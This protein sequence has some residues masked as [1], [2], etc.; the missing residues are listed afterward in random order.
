MA[1]SFQESLTLTQIASGEESTA[2]PGYG[3][4]TLEE[5]ATYDNFANTNSVPAPAYNEN[6][7]VFDVFSDSNVS[8]IDL[9]KTVNV[10]SSQINL[11]QEKNSQYIPFSLNRKSDGYDLYNGIIWIITDAGENKQPYA[12]APVNVY[13]TED[14]VYFGWLIDDYITREARTV[15]FEIH[16]HGQVQGK[17]GTDN[18]TYGYVWKSKTGTLNVTASKF[19][20]NDALAE[21]DPDWLDKIIKAAANNVVTGQVQDQVN[22][23]NAAVKDAEEYKKSAETSAKNAADLVN[24]FDTT[25]KEAET[26]IVKLAES[27]VKS[28]VESQIKDQVEKITWDQEI[29]A[30]LGYEYTAT[31]NDSGYVDSISPNVAEY[32]KQQFNDQNLS[33]PL[34]NYYTK[35]EVDTAIKNVDVSDSLG[36]LGT[37]EDG[38]PITVKEYVDT[39]IENVDVTPKLDELKTE[40]AE[41][42]AT[43]A[44]V[45]DKIGD[46]GKDD[47]GNAYA[48]VAAAIQDIDISDSLGELGIKEDGTPLTVKEY[49]DT[50]IENVDVSD[51]LGNYALTSTVETLEEEVNTISSDLAGAVSN[52]ANLKTTV[53]TLQESAA[54]IYT[55]NIDYD[56]TNNLLS[57]YEYTDEE[58]GAGI[59]KN[60]V[61]ITG[62]SGGGASGSSIT[63]TRLTDTPV[64]VPSG[65]KAEIKY[66]IEAYEIS[67]TELGEGLSQVTAIWKLEGKTIKTETL[68][69]DNGVYI[70]A[71]DITDY[72]TSIKQRFLLTITA[73]DGSLRTKDWQAYNI[74]LSLESPF[75]DTKPY[76]GEV[77]FRYV[78]Y[79]NT[80][81]VIHFILDNI[82]LESVTTSVSGSTQVYTL[83]AQ[84]HGSHLLEV[85]ATTT[86]GEQTLESNHIYKDI[87]WYDTS[88]GTAVIGSTY[89]NFTARQY[90]STAIEYVVYID[91][92]TETTNATLEASYI[93]ETTGEKVVESS[94]DV[95]IAAGTKQVW[96]YKS[97]ILGK[98]TLTI[99]VG[100][101]VK[102]LTANIVE[103]G[104]DI[105]PVTAG[106][107]FDFD[108]VGYNND[109][110]NRIWSYTNSNGETYTMTLSDNFDWVN[111]GYQIDENGDQYFLIK[112]GTTA[113]INY[114][115]FGDDAKA[116]GKEFKLIF[117][118]ENV[119]DSETVFL[120]CLSEVPIVAD[121]GSETYEQVGFQM[122][123][124]EATVY[125]KVETL[126][127][128]YAE[129]S[130]IEFE[131]NI[132][133]KNAVPSMVMGYEDGV[134]TRPMVYDSTHEFQQRVGY[135][136]NI[137]LGSPDCDL[138][139]YRF[140][141]YNTSLSDV[142]IL[143]NFI[144]DARNAEEMI[145]RY[146]RNQIYDTLNNNAL[147]PEYLAKMCP[148]LRIIKIECPRFTTDK[149]D[150]VGY[151]SVQMIYE[152]GDPNLDN[153][154]TEDCV[155]SGQG[156]SSNNYGP[157]G[158]NLDLILKKFSKKGVNYNTN[159][160]IYYK[161]GTETDKV[162]LTRTSVP[163]DYFNIK[164]NI[165]S[166]ENANNALLQKRYNQYNPY[167]RP[168]VRY[169]DALE[170][171]YSEEEIAA[172]TESQKAEILS[173]YQAEADAIIPYIKDTMEFHNCVIFLRET[174]KY[175]DG[176]DAQR[177][178][179]DDDAWHFYA[180]GNIG[181]S[182]KT[183]NTRLTDPRDPYEC[184]IEVMDNTMPL[185]TFPTGYTNKDGS[186][187]YPISVEE[188]ETM[189]NSAY[190][191]LS[192]EEF[193]EVEAKDKENGLDD[194]YGMRY[195]WED[196]TDEE[197]EA[198]WE[199]VKDKWKEF[200][201]F[202]VTSS[203]QEFHDNLGDYVVLNSILYYYLFTLRYT[204]TD[205]HAKN[206]FWHYGKSNDLDENGKPIR[207]WDLCF[208]YDN[209]TALGIDNYGRM[210]YR[211][212]YEEID[213]VDGTT[214]WVWNAPQH[215]FFLRIRELFDAELS[216]LFTTL[217]SQGAFSADGLIKQWNESQ[218][219]FPE[220]LWRMDIERKYIRTYTGSYIN[221]PA[222]PEFL[223]ERA[224]GRKK[225]QRE[226]FERSQE[227][228]M[229][230]KFGGNVAAGDDI[231]L[232]C[233]PDGAP[234]SSHA[235]VPPNFDLTLTPFSYMYLNVKY[236]TASPVKIRAIPNQE[237]TITYNADEADIMEIYSASCLKSLGDLS[238]LYLINGSFANASKIRELILGNATEGYDNANA[239]SLGLGA[240]NL[241]NK[242]NIQNMSGL[243]QSLNLSTL[244]NLKELY[245]FGTSSAG[246]TFADGGA[247]EVV[248][249]PNLSSLSMKNLSYLLDSGFATEGFGKLSS[250]IAENSK[251]DLVPIIQAATNLY[252]VR[253][254]GVNW[255][256][257]DETMTILDRLY[258]MT[259][260]SNS[261]DNI[262]QSVLTGTV[263]VPTINEYTL[264][265]YQQAW[266]ELTI[267]Y[268]AM[269]YQYPVT[270]VNED[271]TILDVQYVIAGQYAIDPITRAEN[272]IPIPTKESTISTDFTF[273]KWDKEFEIVQIFGPE[274]VTATYT[275]SVRKYN[276]E[277]V[278][279]YNGQNIKL[280]S[281]EE[282]VEYGS[283]VPYVGDIPTYTYEESS[284]KYYVFE[285][286]D[287]SGFVWEGSSGTDLETG[288]KIITAN[289]GDGFQ[290]TT[291]AFANKELSD[292]TPV[293]IYAIT[294]LGLNTVTNIGKYDEE[295]GTYAGLQQMDEYSFYM[296]HDVNYDDIDGTTIFREDSPRTFTGATNSL[297]NAT[298]Y[299]DTGIKLFDKDK[300]FVLA[301]DFTVDGG[302]ILSQCLYTSSGLGFQ[303]GYNNGSVSLSWNEKTAT[304]TIATPGV[305][306][307]V[308]LRHKAGDPNLYLYSS[309]LDTAEPLAQTIES[310]KTGT[311]IGATTL[312]FG[313]QK[314]DAGTFRNPGVG[315]VHWAKIWWKDLGDDVCKELVGWTHEKIVLEIDGFDR[316][317]IDNSVNL[318]TMSLLGKQLLDRQMSLNDANSNTGGYPAFKIC[319]ILNTRFYN[320]M[321]WPIQFLTK[322][323]LSKYTLG[324]NTGEVSADKAVFNVL[325]PTYYDLGGSVGVNNEYL[326][327]S[328]GDAYNKT[329]IDT[330]EERIRKHSNG[331][332][333]EYW[334]RSAAYQSGQNWYS[335]KVYYVDANGNFESFYGYPSYAKG[336]LIEISF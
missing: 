168:F 197:N 72:I 87:L 176:S 45:N 46:L 113:E 318:T 200:Y 22:A 60:A 44:S 272:P 189:D 270:F 273:A 1:L 190:S 303:L 299:Y 69:L 249:L 97:N 144:S 325:L 81:K 63:I 145:D 146:D 330:P 248:E 298:D 143:N 328:G 170:D 123:A 98:H 5:I 295:T 329:Y 179:F 54:A 203:D 66:K 75:D 309:N 288:T 155:H 73:E 30:I 77:S 137:L 28:E 50:A 33:G 262:D 215:V 331:K 159:P 61:T 101:V 148:D 114:E 220:E 49:V 213:F 267:N 324:N 222:Y 174:G 78:P 206:C 316:Y 65:D 117:K 312:V 269:N 238:P 227:K 237:Y 247:I 132:S 209:D 181:D 107:V 157:S 183:D 125:A 258:N 167:K 82:E 38:T 163:V 320:A 25:V 115:L 308:V 70:G 74:D 219:Q 26:T 135:K 240:N 109:S 162:S 6:Y 175:A 177:T 13:A 18:I 136:K 241:L 152:N 71:F 29:P 127:L 230:S 198:A 119:A 64:V 105:E 216:T 286:W 42:Y 208:D 84:E 34:K 37:K 254:V 133:E 202:V 278:I 224:N 51:Q 19:N 47:E 226:Q 39:A 322:P 186:P 265:A 263:Y 128:P 223:K 289:F 217:E 204:M 225:T 158:R 59:V 232:R 131:F 140:K 171:H 160:K 88:V 205:N 182:K 21:Y 245:S 294:K 251:L 2:T 180:M 306:E 79:G 301:V 193:D 243:T 103:L 319:K 250:L 31:T 293:E 169:G 246:V 244:L 154:Y 201:K 85:Y 55:Y 4:A 118:T 285:G 199:Y 102:T 281:P 91:A 80:S 274:T 111:G 302:A 233:A 147:T 315:T 124:H 252:R 234:A 17:D 27:Q 259:G 334:T 8:I 23:V 92:T 48:S 264:Y 292:L 317:S 290:Y 178:E 40:I 282:P 36:E 212:G 108:P 96:P 297:G 130:I 196:G 275:D 53:E 239:M 261:G 121:D 52:V 321:P 253:I 67:G 41:N 192:Y 3:A 191:A 211:Y 307:I 151:T 184:I 283:Y 332:V 14:K 104:I 333:G 304:Q 214:Q 172:M 210:S 305:R 12:V 139:V 280:Y 141:V 194:T 287:K 35:D 112:S 56:T 255:T 89:Q 15:S 93:D 62:G 32:V 106:L 300:D 100:D 257:T 260:F 236:N 326:A 296:G 142:E 120:D 256:L 95:I 7:L 153:W 313:A 116:V 231:I 188:W 221:G 24:S 276:V 20:M 43:T 76:S 229:S 314:T 335:D 134:S 277:Y 138:R 228:Y 310:T 173:K 166:S 122:K 57:L 126:P 165:A 187:K 149:S 279:N 86:I 271:G 94:T 9:T 164:V 90:E 323:V 161:D 68:S 207:K 195:L 242:L 10:Q 129:D 110:A 16:I 284:Y 327:E 83:P 291:N 336:V 266:P 218:A 185:S 268:G 311:G 11:T 156:T 235:V 58:A 150:Y 99:T